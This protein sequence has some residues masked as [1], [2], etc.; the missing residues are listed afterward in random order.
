MAIHSMDTEL[1]P[2]TNANVNLRKQNTYTGF[3][4]E[5]CLGITEGPYTFRFACV[6]WKTGDAPLQLPSN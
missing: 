1:T 2:D 4:A 6:C 3:T 5:I